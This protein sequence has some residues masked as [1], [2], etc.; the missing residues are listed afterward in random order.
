MEMGPMMIQF[1]EPL[2]AVPM[3]RLIPS[4]ATAAAAIYKRHLVTRSGS[5]RNQ[6]IKLNRTIP[7][8]MVAICI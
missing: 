1:F 5:W 7:I 6:I 2:T 3:I 4:T 8:A